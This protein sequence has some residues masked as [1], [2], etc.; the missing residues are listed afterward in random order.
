MDG[1]RFVDLT[2]VLALAC[3]AVLVSSTH[4]PSGR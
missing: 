2:R 3:P 1:Q 4:Q